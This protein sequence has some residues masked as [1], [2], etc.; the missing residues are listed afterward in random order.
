MEGFLMQMWNRSIQA[1]IIICVVLAVRLVFSIGK[2]PKRFSYALW[3]IPFLRMLLPWQVESE[4]S[5]M[6]ERAFAVGSNTVQRA[7]G[8]VSQMGASAGSQ[9]AE[10][11]GAVA[12][13]A[14]KGM[15]TQPF[16][17]LAGVVWLAG[18]LLLFSYSVVSYWKLKKQ[19]VCSVRMEE[20]IF[21][22][23]EI[24]TPFVLGFFRPQVYLPSDIQE[25]EI[26][27][28]VAHERT[29]I[30]RGDHIVKMTAFFLTCIYWFFPPAWLA[31]YLMGKDMEMS[32]DEAVMRQFGESCRKEY[33]SVL[34]ALAG[35][36]GRIM[37]VPL[38]FSE[39]NTKKRIVN[40][41]KYKKPIFWGT[42]AGIAALVVLAA[43]LL[44]SPKAE[45]LLTELKEDLMEIPA[46]DEFD[47][48]EVYRN[49]VNTALPK[50]YNKV[51]IEYLSRMKIKRQPLS[52]DSGR[53]RPQDI[54]ISFSDTSFCLYLDAA[55]SE[56]W[57][58]NGT[59][60]S[61]SYQIAAEEEALGTFLDRQLENVAGEME[62]EEPQDVYALVE[63]EKRAAE[64][65]K[66]LSTE[67]MRKKDETVSEQP[68]RSD[69]YGLSV[70]QETLTASGATIHI[71]NQSGQTITCS[72]DFH[73]ARLEGDDWVDVPYVIDNWGFHQ[74]AYTIEE[75]GLSMQ[76]DWEWLYGKL[77]AGTYFITKTISISEDDG[78]YS[79]IGLGS[80]FVLE[81]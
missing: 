54:Q 20:N 66:R 49:G 38:A 55:G 64:N 51:F 13:E 19:L 42:V 59:E 4:F 12:A 31:F 32:C 47:H 29:H 8:Y 57:C 40:I 10:G 35:G 7:V 24:T 18:V 45:C 21:L 37:G 36:R 14:G 68:W 71:S 72:D 43:G 33:A 46:A 53:N 81:E 30:G 6:P 11:N 60:S 63:A 27:Y 25:N 26:T 73:L 76:V 74:P 58:E 2:V 78:A 28:V 5:M 61:L 34:L 15:F 56:I 41:M 80:M 50:E 77:S 22:A 75:D 17:L 44:T 52:P 1:G 79:Q 9:I 23:D 70:E 3:A 62:R 39:G 16:V 48:I 69:L 65:T 67:E